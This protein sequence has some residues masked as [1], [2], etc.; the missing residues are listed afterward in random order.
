MAMQRTKAPMRRRK[1]PK[2]TGEP[3]GGH[4]PDPP[5]GCPAPLVIRPRDES[6]WVDATLC[7]KYCGEKY[8]SIADAHFKAC[9]EVY[10]EAME[11]QRQKDKER[12]KENGK[13]Q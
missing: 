12:A 4:V 9:R 1:A 3:L 2:K 13:N 7:V 5:E 11:R 10:R 8:C 6:R